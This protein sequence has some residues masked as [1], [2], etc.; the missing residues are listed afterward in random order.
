[1]DI[2]IS[3]VDAPKCDG[4]EQPLWDPAEQA[5]YYIDNAGRKIHRYDPATGASRSWELPS[6]ITSLALRAGGG[7]VV[8]LRTGIHFL[9]L[10]S[11]ALEA[12]S[13]LADP[14]PFVFND[15]KADGK[16]RWLI[17]ASTANFEEPAP[18]GGLYRF[19]SDRTLTRLDQGVHFSNG[20]CFSPDG[21]T[22]YFSDS[23]IKTC[24]AYDYDIE[25]G[26]VANRRVFVDTTELGGLPDGATVD[27]EGLVWIAIYG[28]GKIAAFRPDGSVERVIDMPV[29][30][31]SSVMF[32]GP[33]LDRLY[34]TTIAHGALGEPVEDGAGYL[35]V[36]E[37]L[38]VR[39]LPEPR[40]AG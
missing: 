2:R 14:P 32:G 21:R 20:P 10:E 16:G 26:A 13:P 27:S 11:G 29:K 24:Y 39:G 4:G 5:L 1:M 34:V 40:Y 15:A 19:D 38:G 25:T 30:L 22:F 33:E 31:V 36:V 23:W 6:V 3:R 12:V 28:G 9:D 8:T 17:G 35:Y 18:D 7:A 37:G